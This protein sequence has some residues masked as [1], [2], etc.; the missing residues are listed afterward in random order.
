MILNFQSQFSPDDLEKIEKEMR[1][2]ID[3]KSSITKKFYSKNRLLTTIGYRING[4]T[5][6]AL[7]DQFL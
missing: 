4:Q 6:Y 2:I 3:L 1:K 5:T 7:E